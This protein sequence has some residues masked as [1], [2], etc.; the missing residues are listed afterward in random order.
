M[1]P[2][3][4]KR[5]EIRVSRFQGR[6]SFCDFEGMVIA[7]YTPEVM[8]G[9]LACPDCILAGRTSRFALKHPAMRPLVFIAK[10]MKGEEPF[11]TLL[12]AAEHQ[13]RDPGSRRPNPAIRMPTA[14]PT[15]KQRRAAATVERRARKKRAKLSR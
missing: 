2:E 11:A 7:P 6:C 5:G 8:N 4:E 13:R 10:A 1:N 15:R 3:T 12:K 14:R 9:E